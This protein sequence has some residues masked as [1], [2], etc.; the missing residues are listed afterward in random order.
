MNK[1][2]NIL[3]KST[4]LQKQETQNTYHRAITKQS[5]KCKVQWGY[6][7]YI[8]SCLRYSKQQSMWHIL[9][10]SGPRL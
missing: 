4:V 9:R 1:S 8:L 6:Q 3:N 7:I 5:L 10:T 2:K